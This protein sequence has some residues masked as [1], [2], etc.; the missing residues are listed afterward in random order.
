MNGA[1]WPKKKFKIKEMISVNS[2]AT[3]VLCSF[4]ICRVPQL[5]MFAWV[6]Q[7]AVIKKKNTTTTTTNNNPTIIIKFISS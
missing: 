1:I 5:F 4:D 2:G 6:V 3:T 7:Y